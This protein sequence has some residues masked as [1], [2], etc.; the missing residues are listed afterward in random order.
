MID[1]AQ[2]DRDVQT[3]REQLRASESTDAVTAMRLHAIRRAALEVAGARRHSPRGVVFATAVVLIVV[4]GAAWIYGRPHPQV[5]VS[6]VDALDVLTD[7]VD[8]DFYEH[9]DM[10]RWLSEPDSTATKDDHV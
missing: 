2:L 6:S 7:D 9:L 4:L 3:L 1:E 5:D 8:S 10:Y